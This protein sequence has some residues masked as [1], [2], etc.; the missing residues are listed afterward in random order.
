[1]MKYRVMLFDFDGTVADTFRAAIEIFR[2]LAE[3]FNLRRLDEEEI[4][5]AR[6]MRTREFMKFM[7]VPMTQLPALASRGVKA[8][9]A[10]IREVQPIT[11]MPEV[12]EELN[13]RGITLGIV[14]SNAEENVAD[15]LRLH[16]I[17]HFSFVRTSS[18]LFGKAH[19]IRFLI[20]KYRFD[21]KEILFVGDETRDIEAAK[22]VGIHMAA[23]SWGYNS[24]RVLESLEPEY[25]LDRPAELLNFA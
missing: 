19:E 4:E 6:D 20:R 3:E 14:T 5:V 24:R 13:K 11:G 21:K 15:F 22:K 10:K 18:R 2:Q 25:L 9:H 16:R 7:G 1:M 23:V 17:E 12:L 8:L